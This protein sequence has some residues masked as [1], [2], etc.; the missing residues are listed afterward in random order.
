MALTSEMV[1][2]R[3]GHNP[4]QHPH[5]HHRWV[6][7]NVCHW[8]GTKHPR[9]FESCWLEKQ[10]SSFLELNLV[11]IVRRKTIYLCQCLLWNRNFQDRSSHRQ[12]SLAT[13]PRPSQKERPSSWRPE[14]RWGIE[15]NSIQWQ[16]HGGNWQRLALFLHSWAMFSC[17]ALNNDIYGMLDL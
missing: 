11:A 1:F 6:I 9:D 3:L 13:R 10:T 8:W 7:Q 15:R 12:N 2:S 16:H 5:I 4:Q 14:I 17:W